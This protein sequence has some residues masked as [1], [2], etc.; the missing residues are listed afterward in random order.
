MHLLNHYVKRFQ[1]KIVIFKL[2]YLSRFWCHKP[3][4][5][6][7]L[8]CQLMFGESLDL[9]LIDDLVSLQTDFYN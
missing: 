3:K 4:A 1:L 8:G 2:S 7:K 5:I 9:P 6:A